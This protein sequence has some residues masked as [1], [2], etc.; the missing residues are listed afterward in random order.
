MLL[1]QVA[2]QRPGRR[3]PVSFDVCGL[4]TGTKF[5]ADIKFRKRSRFG[6]G[7]PIARTIPDEAES[8]RERRI[9]NIDLATLDPGDYY[10]DVI[11]TDQRGSQQ[12][13]TVQFK[14]LNR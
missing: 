3:L 14:L 2:D 9:H 11:V 7:T 13:K 8:A 1:D 12:G 6:G 5:S 10:L 4:A